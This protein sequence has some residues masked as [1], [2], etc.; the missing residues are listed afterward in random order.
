VQVVSMTDTRE[1]ARAKRS[2]YVRFRPLSSTA[3]YRARPYVLA[4]ARE[5]NDEC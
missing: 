1:V 4:A 5:R 3:S 2:A